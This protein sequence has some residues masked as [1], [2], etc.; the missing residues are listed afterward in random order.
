[1]NQQEVSV[2]IFKALGHPI[3]YKIVKF[4]YDGPKCVCKLNENIEFS[5]ANLSQHLKI[6]KEAGVLLSEKVGMETHYRI[7]SEEIKNIIDS[8]EKYVM[9]YSDN[10]K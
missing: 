9:S 2:R 4:L 6:L 10:S 1:M 7:S 8:V 3:R 5:Q